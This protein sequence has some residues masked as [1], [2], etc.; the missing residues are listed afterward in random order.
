M[1]VKTNKG[2]AVNLAGASHIGRYDVKGEENFTQ[3]YA[4]Y[5]ASGMNEK[6]GTVVL[7]EGERTEAAEYFEHLA[8]ALAGSG[9]ARSK[10]AKWQAKQ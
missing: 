9:E 4:S 7:F 1:W 10:L 3:V 2:E 5:P 8:S 6:A